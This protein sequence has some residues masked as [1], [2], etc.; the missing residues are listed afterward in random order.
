MQPPGA[1]GWAALSAFNVETRL[2]LRLP[3]T[4]GPAPVDNAIDISFRISC[5]V[6]NALYW[7]IA[8][9]SYRVDPVVTAPDIDDNSARALAAQLPLR[10]FN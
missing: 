5:V 9:S 1:L 7:G 3:V 4:Q 10:E 6:P 2:A 8:P